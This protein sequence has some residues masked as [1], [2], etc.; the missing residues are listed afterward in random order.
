ME[1]LLGW[2]CQHANDAYWLVF[3]ILFLAGLNIPISEDIVLITAG[4]LA[5]TCLQDDLFFFFLCCYLA[6]WMSAWQVYWI[7]RLLGPKLYAISWFKRMASPDR[8]ERLHY[9]YERYGIWTFIG[10]RFIP[11]GV[12]NALFLT[13]GLGKMPFFRFVSRDAVAAFFS[14][15]WLFGIGYLFAE[16]HQAVMRFFKKY[17]LVAIAVIALLIV[18]WVIRR[19]MNKS[20][21]V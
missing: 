16:H 12:R 21:N 14:T 1:D 13:C 8:I 7:G 19:Q 18:I 6:A 2:A 3:A 17:N 11:G 20:E 4:A 5:R 10:G 9:Y 15:V